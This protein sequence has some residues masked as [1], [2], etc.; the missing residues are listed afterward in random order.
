MGIL[1]GLCGGR[2]ANCEGSQEDGV[3]WNDGVVPQHRFQ[4]YNLYSR[5]PRLAIRE[6]SREGTTLEYLI[7]I[8]YL[9]KKIRFVLITKKR[10]LMLFKFKTFSIN[11]NA[12][13]V[14][15]M[16]LLLILKVHVRLVDTLE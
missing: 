9:K 8:R 14:N 10:N 2:G 1:K 7:T 11:L 5:R 13:H 6:G 3:A 12:Q 4:H 16:T 15:G